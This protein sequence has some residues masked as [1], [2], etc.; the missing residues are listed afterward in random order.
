LYPFKVPYWNL[1]TSCGQ[2]VFN[3][4]DPSHPVELGLDRWVILVKPAEMDI[5]AG[6][7]APAISVTLVSSNALLTLALLV[8]TPRLSILRRI[9]LTALGML[10]LFVSHVTN[11][12]FEVKMYYLTWYAHSL[13]I[14]YGVFEAQTIK[15]ISA[16]F[17]Y[18]RAQLF[19]FLIWGTLCYKDLFF[20][21]G[22]KKT[23]TVGKNQPC[24]CGSGVKFKQC[25]G[26]K[27]AE[28]QPDPT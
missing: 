6:G 20:S 16:L 9:K 26:K 18:F 2:W 17:Q 19:P 24:P 25:C 13:G 4:L 1:L 12:V 28:R 10:I 23:E 27:G 14:T 22:A 15:W 8:S 3:F 21:G 7:R 5:G 11:I